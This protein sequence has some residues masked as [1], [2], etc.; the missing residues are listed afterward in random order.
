MAKRIPHLIRE[1]DFETDEEEHCATRVRGGC[2]MVVFAQLIPS[3]AD[4]VRELGLLGPRRGTL[5]DAG[6]LPEQAV[7]R[8]DVLITV[9]WV[10]F[11]R[12]VIVGGGR[13]FVLVC[14]W[15]GLVL[16]GNVR[17]Q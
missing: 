4:E 10:V 9:S 16:G 14:E 2:S 17:L 11:I 7:V 6:P 1:L 15:A 13:V 3:R 5:G 12:L 8:W